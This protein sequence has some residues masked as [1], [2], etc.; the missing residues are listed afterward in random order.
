MLGNIKQVR[1]HRRRLLRATQA[2]ARCRHSFTT[3][4]HPLI[5]LPPRLVSPPPARAQLLH[6]TFGVRG[7]RNAA[8]WIVAGGLAY[9]M[10]WQPEQRRRAE[11]EVR[12]SSA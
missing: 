12:S 9:Y 10:I 5:A 7:T 11:I 3:A 1:C 8:S 4:Q 2:P 6:V